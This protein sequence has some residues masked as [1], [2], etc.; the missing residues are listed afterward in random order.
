VNAASGEKI[1]Y[2][3][4]KD[5]A[6]LIASEDRAVIRELVARATAAL[7]DFVNIVTHSIVTTTNKSLR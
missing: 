6:P 7:L 5:V 2:H 4:G 1:W 3:S